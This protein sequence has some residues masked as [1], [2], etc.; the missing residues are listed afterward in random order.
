MTTFLRQLFGIAFVALWT[1]AAPAAD[2]DPLPIDPDVTVKKLPNG[3]TYY[4]RA[5]K[6]P[7]NRAQFHLVVNAGSILETEKQL[8]LAH[9]LEHMAFNGTKNFEKNEIINFL[10]RT[11]MQFGADLNAYTSFD[12]TAYRLEVPMDKPDV[13]KKAFQVLEDW[14][15]NIEFDAK[16]IEKERGVI[17]EEWRTGRGAGGRLRDKQFPK[18]FHQSLYAERLPIG[19]TNC[20]ATVTREDFLDYYTKWYRP[21]LMAVIAVGDFDAKKIEALIIEHFS[22]L[23]NPPNAPKRPLPAVPDHEGTLFSIETD[24]ELSS[25]SIQIACKHPLAPD[26]SASDYRRD[27]VEGI[28]SQMLNQRI[29]E[30]V[31]EAKPPYLFAGVGKSHMVRVK[32]MASMRA[33]VKEGL[34]PEGLKA[35][36]LESRRARRDGFTAA[37]FERARTV[38]LRSMERA[39]EE[40]DKTPSSAYVREYSGN[41]LE[42][43]PIPGIAEELKLTKRFLSDI[44]LTEVNRAGDRWITDTNRV[45][46]FSAPEKSGLKKPTEA[47]ILSIIK[48]ADSAEIAAYSD[49]AFEAPLLTNAPKAGTI[50]SEKDYKDVEVTEWILSNGI[51]VLLKPTTFKND[52]I[53]MN[54]FSP[55]GHSLVPDKD[56]LS[57]AMSA[58]ILSQSGWGAYDSIQLRKKLAGKIAS[59]GSS[60]GEQFETLSGSAS[61]KDLETWFQLMHLHFIAP[62]SDE[63]TF[64]SY[65]TRLKEG[66]ENR[67][68]NPAAVF[69]DEIEKALYGDH[70]R[71]RPMTMEML[72]ELDREAAL[73]IYRERFANAGD[74]TFVFVGAFKPGDLRPLVQTYLASLPASDRKESGRHVGD[75][76]KRG[77]LNVEVKKGIEPKA[78]VRLSFH[79]D[80]Q[81]S[82][83]ERYALRGAVDVLRIRLREVMREDKGGVYGVGVYGDIDRLPRQTFFSGITFTCNPDNVADLTQAALDEIKR[84]QTDGPN[85]ENL[86]KVRE[87]S[88]RNYERSLKEDSFWM[89]N[90]V[91]YREN[92]LPFDGILKLPDRA[93]ALTVEKVRDAARKYFSD[94]NLLIARLLPEAAQSASSKGPE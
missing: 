12:E 17:T 20:I 81:W 53:M 77:K 55:G 34:W 48:E 6:K 56:Y 14:A 2:S 16:E 61:P 24:P 83:D 37:E 69:G 59:V 88:L 33:G 36:L 58:G 26:G 72:K 39:F 73:R 94:E 50:V 18:L 4:I 68:R 49:G 67:K 82:M 76:P 38:T 74:F 78:S 63:K 8:G 9:F 27:L 66:I 25:T 11:G 62:R 41:F 91:F 64:Q 35:L 21:D 40:R 23:K 54:A 60:I 30:R 1:S 90:L 51:R 31:L 75:D 70:P 19:T 13:V 42:N 93:K 89:A 71:H 65:V 57:A 22:H 92:E 28:Y 45:I 10:E 3:L 80:A 52:S 85:A 86:E 5:N 32:D 46:L 87:T 7:E 15:H 29:G 44:T 79:G 43:E 47:E 84:L